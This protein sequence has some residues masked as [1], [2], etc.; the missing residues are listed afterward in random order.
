MLVLAIVLARSASVLGLAVLSA[1]TPG[2]PPAGPE[3]AA[4]RTGTLLVRAPVLVSKTWD[5][6]QI[7]C[8]GAVCTPGLQSKGPGHPSITDDGRTVFF[9]TNATDLYPGGTPGVRQ[10]FVR[11]VQ[12]GEVGVASA[13][14]ANGIADQGTGEWGMIAGDGT[15]AVFY[16]SDPDLSPGPDPTGMAACGGVNGANVFLKEVGPFA[17]NDPTNAPLVLVSRNAAGE[18]PD[19]PSTRPRVSDELASGAHRVAY[20]SCAT[21]LALANAGPVGPQGG[22]TD[23]FLYD[24]VEGEAWWVSRPEADVAPEGPSSFGDV[25]AGGGWVTFHS[26]A[27]NL[28][29]G[30][31][32][33]DTLQVYVRDAEA[34]TPAR[35]VSHPPSR[36][37]RRADGNS[38][39]PAVDRTGAHVA[40]ASTSTQLVLGIDACLALRGQVYVWEAATDTVEL[41]SKDPAGQPGDGKSHRPRIS[42]DGRF[43]VFTSGAALVPEDTDDCNDVY[44]HDRACDATYLISQSTDRFCGL[45][46]LSGDGRW[47]V[48][49]TDSDD[50]AFENGIYVDNCTASVVPCAPAGGGGD[51]PPP[52]APAPCCCNPGRDVYRVRVL[53]L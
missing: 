52:P 20:E 29:A 36:P 11:D 32:G 2:A 4:P 42:D 14:D 31:I 47:V 10:H 40:F 28:A 37:N 38:G 17:G 22:T 51:C 21:D 41:V 49:S 43:V 6:E 7:G 27:D 39:E 23:V 16:H 15:V 13:V 5:G 26:S 18:A 45:V 35:L 53:E 19:G 33:P 8:V 3:P 12:T 34:T 48:F 30:L 50:S 1:A 25:A 46:D 9:S 44:L 24:T